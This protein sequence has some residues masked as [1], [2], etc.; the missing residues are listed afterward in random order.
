MLINGR[1][2]PA[3]LAGWFNLKTAPLANVERIEVLRGPASSLYGGKT[4]GGAIN[5]IT[6]DGRDVEKPEFK[7][8][9]EGGSFETFRESVSTLGNA[10]PIDWSLKGTRLDS[11]G[12][13][14]NS[15]IQQTNAGGRFGAQLADSLR[16][17]LDTGYYD[18]E[19][20]VPGPE[21]PATR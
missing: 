1:P 10:G 12:P 15:D 11:D 13:R 4:I 5:I 16:V 20:G 9:A 18:A 2:A 7:L 21:Y 6:R 8:W 17:E 14:V 3:N 19:F